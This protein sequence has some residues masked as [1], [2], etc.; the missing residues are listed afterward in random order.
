MASKNTSGA[1]K[2]VPF[3]PLALA[4]LMQNA[5]L[6][7]ARTTVDKSVR[8][9][10]I[11]QCEDVESFVDC[12]SDYPTGCT[13]KPGGIYDPFLNL[14]KNQ[15]IPVPVDPSKLTYL[16]SAG[17]FATLDRKLPDGLGKKNHGDFQKELAALGEGGIVASVGYFYYLQEGTAET[18]NCKLTGEENTDFHVGIGFDEA[19]ALKVRSKKALTAGEK[20]DLKRTSVIVEMTPHVRF[21]NGTEWNK[22]GLRKVLGR[23]VRVAG[24]LM[25]DNEHN[26]ASQNCAMVGADQSKCWRATAWEMHPVTLFQFCPDESCTATSTNWVEVETAVP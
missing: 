5:V 4:L 20:R 21:A 17:D 1:S 9:A 3:A 7:T 16:N 18:S 2:I 26:I 24:Q 15:L 6:P 8:K 19:L 10:P 14:M 11:A 25:F 22:E 12:H 13:D 23:K